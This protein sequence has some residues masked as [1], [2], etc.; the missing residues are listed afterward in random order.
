M[1]RQGAATEDERIHW[2][3]E[4]HQRKT[5]KKQKDFMM[6]WCNVLFRA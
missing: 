3:G 5:F 4:S 2:A 1:A 6:E